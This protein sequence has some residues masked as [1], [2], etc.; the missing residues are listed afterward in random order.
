MTSVCDTL[1][2]Y[3]MPNHIHFL[4]KTH[5]EEV[6][7]KH[8]KYELDFHKLVMQQL[9]NLLNSYAKAC[10]KKYQRRGATLG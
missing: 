10:N 4:L 8:P 7:K 3:L 5:S 1:A 6:I 2:Y 9:S